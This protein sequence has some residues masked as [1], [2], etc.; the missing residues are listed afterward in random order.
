M[1]EISQTLDR[2]LRLL[3]V[4]SE[5]AGGLSVA[6]AST[7]LGVNRT[8]VY[9]LLATLEQHGLVRRASNGRFSVGFGVLSLAGSVHP[10][11]RHVAQPVLRSLAEEIGATAHLTIADGVEALAVAVVEPTRTDF[12]VAYRI[13]SRH[14]LERGAAGRAILSARVGQPAYATSTGELEA[15]AQGVAAPVVA[16]P[17]VEASIGVIALGDLDADVVGPQTMRAAEELTRRLT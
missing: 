4:L 17:G 11:L 2:G 9:R 13:G 3:E 8:I 7:V 10:W 15:G 1:V 14:P 5:S 16:V 12:H 6:E